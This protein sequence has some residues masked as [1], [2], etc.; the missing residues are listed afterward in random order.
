MIQRLLRICGLFAAVVLGV[1]FLL[2]AFAG[3]LLRVAAHFA[4]QSPLPQRS[5]EDDF[6]G[7]EKRANFMK[8]V[9][10]GAVFAVV[11]LLVAALLGGLLIA[12]SG[13]VPIAA[14][15]GH[16][17]ITEWFLQFAKRRSISTHS[18]GIDVP[19]LDDPD[20]ILKGATHYEIGC[21]P[22]HGSPGLPLPRIPA[23]MLPH[24]PDLRERIRDAK[25][26]ELFYV[27][28]HGLKFTGMPAW[29]ASQREDE[30]WAVV[31]F[32]RELTRLD[33]TEYRRLVDGESP[34]TP[35]TPPIH[36]MGGVPPVPPVVTQSCAR[37]HGTDG[38][39]RGTG[40]FPKLAG[41]REAYLEN[42][43][44]AYARGGRHSGIMEPISAGLGEEAIRDVVGYYASAVPPHPVPPNA[45][46]EA[47]IERGEFIAEHGIPAQ[48]VPSC[49]DC[50][51][52]EGRDYN[53]NYPALEAQHADY[54]LLQLELFKKSHR[55]GSAYAHIMEPIA[56]RLRPEQMRDV[57]LYFQSLRRR[58]TVQAQGSED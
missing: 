36:T 9:K 55:G 5:D 10:R 39:G 47:A 23:S 19:P 8:G 1:A 32:L 38:I 51:A 3:V 43:L 42:A 4:M 24:P 40:A 15:S 2:G 20:L 18:L 29:P 41:Q 27:V 14:S 13:V 54:L 52:P 48:R 57:A 30:V 16:W 7:A 21:R 6:R 49:L 12:V 44:R 17:P 45:S 26:S 34:A 33:Q 25:P 46:D 28:K 22:C 11:G 56:K 50:H 37:C 53:A 35:L 31:A 58:H